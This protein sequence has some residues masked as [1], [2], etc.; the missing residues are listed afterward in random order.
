M[1]GFNC[2]LSSCIDKAFEVSR[3]L[4]YRPSLAA[5]AGKV[6]MS[7]SA[8]DDKKRAS[9]VSSWTYFENRRMKCHTHN[10]VHDQHLSKQG[11][12]R[13]RAL[14]LDITRS[15]AAEA[16]LSEAEKTPLKPSLASLTL[17]E[18]TAP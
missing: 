4:N 16:E 14:V 15:E 5:T 7:V 6:Q 9:I 12:S 3:A 1:Q 13:Y 8:C 2:R 18:A 10:I 11:P 17:A